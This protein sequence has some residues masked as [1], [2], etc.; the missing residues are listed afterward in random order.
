MDDCDLARLRS[1]S[2]FS[3]T[4]ARC[5]GVTPAPARQSVRLRTKSA[6]GHRAV[7]PRASV[8]DVVLQAG[9]LLL[10]LVLSTGA[11]LYRGWSK[12]RST[13]GEERA[14]PLA[15]LPPG[16]WLGIGGVWCY[17]LASQSGVF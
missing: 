3:M 5:G 2:S 6:R 12:A 1:R 16:M 11:A 8:N 17:W 4:L 15:A 10:P 9:P 13:S 7:V 14:N